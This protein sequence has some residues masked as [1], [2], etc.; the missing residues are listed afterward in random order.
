MSSKIS[1]LP[2]ASTI[3]ATDQLEFNQAGVS[4]RGTP[5]QLK[6]FLGCYLVARFTVDDVAIPATD[7][8][9]LTLTADYD[10]LST[11]SAADTFTAPN[12]GLYLFLLGGGSR[13]N[14]NGTIW[15]DANKVTVTTYINGAGGETLA[16]L[17]VVGAST[18]T[19][20]HLPLTGENTLSL[21][22]GD[23][24]IFEAENFTSAARAYVGGT[25]TVLRV[26]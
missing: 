21:A 16:W 14:A 6:T 5:A 18:A 15:S 3:N 8:L 23:D 20:I 4:R 13:V 2:A 26:A 9:N 24:V 1:G 17:S 7:L 11:L 12:T 19:N 10:P 25:L 22:A